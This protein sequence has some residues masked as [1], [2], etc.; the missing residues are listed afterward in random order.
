MPAGK[1]L[2]LTSGI[3]GAKEEHYALFSPFY[4]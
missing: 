2:P 1:Q 3:C 4:L